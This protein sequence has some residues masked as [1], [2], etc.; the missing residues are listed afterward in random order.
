MGERIWEENKFHKLA[1]AKMSN[2][3][4]VASEFF[5]FKLC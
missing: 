5:L 4:K 2:F 1:Q 3:E